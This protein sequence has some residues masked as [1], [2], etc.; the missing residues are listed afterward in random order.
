MPVGKR[1]P[2]ELGIYDMSGNVKEWCQDWYGEYPSGAV[3]NPQG[4]SSGSDRVIRGG[5]W[6][7]S[8]SECRVSSRY[9]I[10]PI[11]W[12]NNFGFRLALLP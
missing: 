7:D 1:K 6:Y 10:N 5:S 8:A 4:A 2:N 3:S 11:S 12:S 9:S